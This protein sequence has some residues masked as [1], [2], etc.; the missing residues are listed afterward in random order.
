[1]IEI[2]IPGWGRLRLARLVLDVN[3]TIAVDG[4]L[5]DGVAE[6]I[7][8]LR[9]RVAV[10]WV[11]ADTHGRQAA[12]DDQLGFRAVRIEPGQEREQKAELVRRLGAEN[13]CYIGNGAN[14]AAALSEAGL[15]IAV[16]GAEGLALEALM[17]AD[18]LAPSICDALDLL[19]HPARLIAK[20]RR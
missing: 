6:R 14:D 4:A 19:L 15:G 5:V 1:M 17:A 11:T 2:E 8:A 20:L 16:L 10:H 3:G 12:L 13:V 18:L 9:E 7:E